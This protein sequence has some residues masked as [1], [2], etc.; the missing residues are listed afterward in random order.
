MYSNILYYEVA[1]ISHAW[2]PHTCATHTVCDSYVCTAVC[3]HA[4]ILYH[5]THTRTHAHIHTHTHIHIVYLYDESTHARTD[6]IPP[7]SL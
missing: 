3:E 1:R 7:L 5:P 6:S 4:C 2:A